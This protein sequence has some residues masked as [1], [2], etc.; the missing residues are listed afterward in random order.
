MVNPEVLL[1]QRCQRQPSPFPRESF[2][3]RRQ[4][5]IDRGRSDL[6]DPQ[7]PVIF[8]RRHTRAILASGLK[9]GASVDFPSWRLDLATTMLERV[10]IGQARFNVPGLTAD[11]RGVVV[12]RIAVLRFSALGRL[13]SF[14][15]LWSGEQ[16]LDDLQPGLRLVQARTAEGTREALVSIPVGSLP[17]VDAVARAARTVGGQ[18]FTGAG[19][20]FVQYRDQRAPLGYDVNRLETVDEG[21][22]SFCTVRT[23]RWCTWWRVNCRS[24]NSCFGWISS[25]STQAQRCRATS[26]I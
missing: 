19:K 24:T 23:T 14:L 26:F 6:R 25:V 1:E 15:R 3:Q 18:C 20:H 9:T 13:V 10:G 4:V 22:I 17:L 7:S 16:A 11:G 21:L 2:G 5:P 12:G 8:G